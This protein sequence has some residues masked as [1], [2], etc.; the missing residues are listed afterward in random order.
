M[1]TKRIFEQIVPQET[2][3]GRD[4][5]PGIHGAIFSEW[6]PVGIGEGSRAGRV[7][8]PNTNAINLSRSWFGMVYIDSL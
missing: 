5:I 8:P 1:Q 2:A 4:P 7:L 3:P 6:V